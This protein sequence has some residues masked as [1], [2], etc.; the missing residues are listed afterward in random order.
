MVN[1]AEPDIDCVTPAG[2][3]SSAVRYWIVLAGLWAALS[4]VSLR[5]TTGFALWFGQAV[6]V[7][8]APLT[9][10]A[11][12]LALLLPSAGTAGAKFLARLRASRHSL[13]GI[14]LLALIITAIGTLLVVGPVP[15]AADELVPIFQARLFSEFRLVAEYD[16][17]ILDGVIPRVSQDWFVLV[18]PDGEAMSVYLPGMALV[19]V[20]FVWL[21]VPW[22]AAP[23]FG[24]ASIF[25]IGQITQYLAGR[26]AAIIAMILALASGQFVLN[27]MAAFPEGLHLGLSLGFAWLVMLGRTRAYLAAGLV[28]GLALA[29]KNPFPHFLFALPWIA[30]L[31]LDRGRRKGLMP[32]MV[33]YLPGLVITGGWL[34]VQGQLTPPSFQEQGG[35]WVSKLGDLVQLPSVF[36]FILRYVELLSAWS[37]SAPGLLVLAFLGWMHARDTRVRLLGLS[38]ATMLAGYLFFPDQ[39]GLGYGARYLHPAWGV[40]PV[41]AGH[42]LTRMW[43]Q[44]LI[45]FTLAA[46]MF[47]AVL[48]LPVQL[49]YGHSLNERRLAPYRALSAPGVDLYFINFR[50]RNGVSEAVLA[51]DYTDGGVITLVSQG[52]ARDRIVIEKWFPGARLVVENEWGAGYDRPGSP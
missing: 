37:W 33:G 39:Q 4:I 11:M 35:F 2:G 45:S 14:P 16:P 50:G 42:G 23:V 6:D 52:K 7:L 47:A 15:I 26:T 20:P 51:D 30:W 38:F 17:L 28:G 1:P 21:G 24:A 46:A 25:L 29:L 36:T 31:L 3:H 22:L 34:W 32:L 13:I 43:D 9:L 40:L 5:A 41:L 48:V 44:R 19:L 49:A 12:L 8:A 18:S 10:I 27:A